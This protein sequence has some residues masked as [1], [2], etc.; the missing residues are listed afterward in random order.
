MS[1]IPRSALLRTLAALFSLVTLLGA[2]RA[3][4]AV[5]V[6]VGV[7]APVWVYYPPPPPYVVFPPYL[8]PG[9]FFI[10]ATFGPFRQRHWHHWR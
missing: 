10:G 8:Y 2:Q 1:F 6:G 4:A 5:A 7:P 3:Q 9:G